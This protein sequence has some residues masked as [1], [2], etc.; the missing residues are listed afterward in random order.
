MASIL[1]IDDTRKSRR[2]VLRALRDSDYRVFMADHDGTS[3]S[4]IQTL[5]PDIILLNRQ[6]TDF[7]AVSLFME[8]KDKFPDKPTLLYVLKTATAIKSFQEAVNMA[9]D[10]KLRRTDIPPILFV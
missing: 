9:L 7:D 6:S 2:R 4:M 3:E 8:I 10:E 1:V 5:K